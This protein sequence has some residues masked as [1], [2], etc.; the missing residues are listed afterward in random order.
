MKIVKHFLLIMKHKY[1]VGYY[2]TKAHITWRGI[3]HDMSKF[4]PTEFLESIKYYVGNRSPI[5]V[6]KEKNGYSNAWL[7][8]K[9]RNPHH[10]EYWQDN[11]DNGGKPLQMPFKYALE[12]ICDYLGAGRAYMKNDFSYEAEYNW[13][14][15]KITKPI[16]MHPQT[17]AFVEIMLSTMAKENS[18]DCLRPNRAKYFY[19]LVSE[20]K[21]VFND[22]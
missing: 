5:D 18:C 7:H 11:F 10:Y 22:K 13:W 12:L 20:L 1:W 3:M 6:C 17:K 9:G 14:K 15:Q 21:G 16:A 19:N 2:C 4:S 8:H